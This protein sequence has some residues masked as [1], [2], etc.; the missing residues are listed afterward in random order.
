M[1]IWKIICHT[2]YKKQLKMVHRFKSKISSYKTFGR[3]QEKI[4]RPWGLVLQIRHQRKVWFIKFHKFDLNKIYNF[5]YVKDIRVMKIQV[6]E[7]E[8]I[9][10]NHIS[11]NDSAR[12]YK[13]LSNSQQWNLLIKY[14]D[15]YWNWVMT[16]HGLTILVSAFL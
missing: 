16:I 3:K 7:W 6:A 8:K 2:L 11:S 1:Y 13:E 5:Y 15:N 12:I 14:V 4:C 10:G 9:F